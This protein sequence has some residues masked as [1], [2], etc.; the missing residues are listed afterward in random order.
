MLSKVKSTV[1][2][3]LL[4]SGKTNLPKAKQVYAINTGTF[5]GEMFVFCK[6]DAE[7]YYFLSIP[8]NVNRSVPI[9]KFN[10]ALD[11]KIAE[12]V[13][14]LPSKVYNICFK[15]YEYNER[16]LDSKTTKLK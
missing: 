13:T 10:F 7:N 15:Q 16:Q 2:Q 11:N 12:Y 6:K 14:D 8:K 9:D 1:L 3:K 5:V 4:T